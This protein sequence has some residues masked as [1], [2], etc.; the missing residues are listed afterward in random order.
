MSPKK[1]KN[2][3]KIS[4]KLLKIFAVNNFNLK[5][6]IFDFVRIDPISC[7]WRHL[8]ILNRVI[9]AFW[10]NQNKVDQL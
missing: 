1:I 7:R 3:F 8:S 6:L 2:C 10:R 4:F 5:K 9:T